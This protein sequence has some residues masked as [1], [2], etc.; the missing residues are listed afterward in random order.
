MNLR[1]SIAASFLVIAL[2][3]GLTMAL[4]PTHAQSTVTVSI[5]NGAGNAGGAPGYAPDN[6]TVVVGVN[7][8]V[9]WTNNDT[10][11]HT[12]TPGNE[13]AG[14]PWSGGS[15]DMPPQASYSFTFTVPGTYSYFCK[16][17]N[18][19]TGTVV[20]KAATSTTTSTPEFPVTSLAVIVFAAMAA[21]IVAA[22][23]LR[24]SRAGPPSV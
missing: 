17:H 9:T 15:P 10:V 18:W 24:P 1:A 6:V 12:V 3:S 16:Y 21:V 11:H 20:V 22:P 23:R 19:M 8:T 2:I 4:P 7:N 13:P 5:P 14:S